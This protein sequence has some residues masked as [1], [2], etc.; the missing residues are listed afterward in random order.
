MVEIETLRKA[1][2]KMFDIL[3]EIDKIC[4]KHD[5][6]YWLCYG[7][8]L[9]AV[10]HKGFI[11]WDDDCDICMMREDY[12]KFIK[13]AQLELPKNLFLQN[14]KTDPAYHRAMD[15]IRM[16]D[17]KLVEFDESENERYHQGIYVDIFI[18]DYYNS[19]TAFILKNLK[20]I[21]DWKYAR[22]KYPKGSLKRISIQIA[23]LLP[24][25]FYSTMIKLLNFIT[26]FDRKNSKYKIIGQEVNSCDMKFFSKNV[27]FPTKNNLLFEGKKFSVPN[28][29]DDILTRLYGDYMTLPKPENRQW[30]AK[31]IEL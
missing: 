29:P 15:K 26:I 6:K 24:Y 18:W 30:H 1:Q 25:L 27:I 31:K 3:V 22:K 10:R 7:T 2:L 5:I 21:N 17:T 8:L 11:P 28:N 13:V 20:I 19:L 23:V 12:E 9:G 16:H 4:T 14:S